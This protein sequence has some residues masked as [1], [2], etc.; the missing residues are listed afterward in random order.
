M[1]PM[2]LG[3]AIVFSTKLTYKKKMNFIET[4]KKLV[5]Y[6]LIIFLIGKKSILLK[7]QGAQPMHT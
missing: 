2:Y 7:A 6:D 1:L 3:C 5:G 4:P